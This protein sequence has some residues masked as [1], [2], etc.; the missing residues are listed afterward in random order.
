[1]EKQQIMEMLAKM[2]ERMEANMKPIKEETKASQA[3]TDANM[4][5]LQEKM[6]ADR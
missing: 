1:M 3:R 6:D 5:A 2:D 4:K